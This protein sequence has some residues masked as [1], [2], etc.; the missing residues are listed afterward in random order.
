MV[1]ITNNDPTRVAEVVVQPQQPAVVQPQVQ[2]SPEARET[3]LKAEHAAAIASAVNQLSKTALDNRWE[4]V[5]NTTNPFLRVLKEIEYF[6]FS[7]FVYGLGFGELAKKDKEQKATI[8]AFNAA[9][10]DLVT[11]VAKRFPT[12]QEAEEKG[13]SYQF[14]ATEA[15]RAIEQNGLVEKK[16]D[17]FY[18]KFQERVT[19]LGFKPNDPEHLKI[20]GIFTEAATKLLAD[21]SNSKSI[22]DKFKPEAIL[23]YGPAGFTL[24]AELRG[25][26]AFP[27]KIQTTID[28]FNAKASS[29]VSTANAKIFAGMVKAYGNQPLGNIINTFKG[30][31]GQIQKLFPKANTV[32][33]EIALCKAILNK[34]PQEEFKKIKDEYANTVNGA[35]NKPLTEAKNKIAKNYEAERKA[36]TERLA[37]LSGERGTVYAARQQ[38]AFAFNELEKAAT[39]YFAANQTFGTRF[40]FVG[41]PDP[42]V[43]IAAGS[44]LDPNN[45]QTVKLVQLF[46]VLKDKQRIFQERDAAHKTLKK[47]LDEKEDKLQR[48]I[49]NS[50]EDAIL[51]AAKFETGR[52]A[53]FYYELAKAVGNINKKEHSAKLNSILNRQPRQENASDVNPSGA[54]NPIWGRRASDVNAPNAR[55]VIW[56]QNAQDVN[57]PNARNVIW[58]QNAQDVNAP[59]AENV[60]WHQNAQDVNAPD[61]ENVIWGQNA[62]DVNAPGADKVIWGRNAQDNGLFFDMLPDDVL[63]FFGNPYDASQINNDSESSDSEDEFARRSESILQ[64]QSV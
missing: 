11:V 57:A 52:V 38:A 50:S 63:P 1:S 18:A 51:S 53:E 39:A 15:A 49:D 6:F 32:D 46:E 31:V 14:N 22:Q 12:Q 27:S 45:P 4:E 3:R 24:P 30:A 59:G 47:E 48:I 20:Y 2:E 19:Q 28:A 40:Q 54:I 13:V 56:G 23:A 8:R 64:H 7:T 21:L 41:Q 35:S 61:A 5:K 10:E 25:P 26:H 17:A 37:V 33:I 9:A 60:I 58:R 42:A 34:H 29:Y 62:Q 43:M 55:N 16:L 36:L 44:P